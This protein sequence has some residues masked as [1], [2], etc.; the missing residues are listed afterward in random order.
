MNF[1]QNPHNLSQEI[2]HLE[3]SI[4]DFRKG[5]MH[6][7]QF[8]GIRVPFG[9]YEQRKDDTYMMRIRCAGG[10]ATPGQLAKVAEL[11]RQYGSDLI[12]ITTRQEMQ[13]HDV[14]LENVPDIMRELLKV[15]LSTRGGG[16]NT[17]R[18][19][20]ASHD[21]GVNLNEIFDVEPYA[22]ALTSRLI[23]ETDSWTLPR[24]FK[25]TFSSLA[26]NNANATVQDVGFI[27]QRKDGQKGFKVYVAGGMG[28]KSRLGHLLYEFVPADR[29]F[30]IVKAVKS[31]FY[32]HGNRKNKHRN[33][34]RFL[35][36]DLGED[37]FLEVF[38]QE[39]RELEK[40][41]SL[42][43]DVR[44][45]VNAT[46][47]A[48]D[49]APLSQDGTEYEHWRQ[50]YVTKQKQTGLVRIKLAL[51][52]GDISSEDVLHLARLL[53]PFG[54][55]LLR[56][57]MDQNI[58]LRNIPE[59]YLG[60]MFQGISKLKTLS[61]QPAM[62]GNMIACTGANTCKLGICLSR[63]VI[64]ATQKMLRD[65]GLD[66]EPLKE[67]KIHISGCPNSCGQHWTG[68]LGFFGVVRRKN[69]RAFPSY[70]V[71]AGAIAE[72]EK[73]QLSRLTSWVPAYDVPN[74]IWDILET[75]LSKKECSAS[76]NEYV[77]DGGKESIAALCEKYQD[78]P[79]FRDDKN[80]YFDW[81]AED[82]FSTSGMGQGECS[83]GLFDLIDLDEKSIKSNKAIT[84]SASN[85][86]EVIAALYNMVFSASRMLLVTKGIDA[87]SSEDVF[88]QFI[89]SFIDIGL[90]SDKY[91]EIVRLAQGEKYL[92]LLKRKDEVLALGD[93]VMSLYNSMDNSLTFP[94]EKGDR[95]VAE[96][97]PGPQRE[98]DIPVSG[99]KKPDRFK[100][101][102]GVQCPMNFVKTKIDLASMQAGQTLEIYLDDGAPID[103]VPRSVE[104]EG[105][106]ILTTTRT[107]NH[108]SVL[109]QKI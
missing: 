36:E 101:Y 20:T 54:E 2:E 23:A 30:Y 21:S 55:N 16:G 12:H 10:G 62:F 108:W 102:R 17:V 81:G 65:T 56:F 83:A 92:E 106:K 107:E 46:P 79:D 100:D 91:I 72:P 51:L 59:D 94:S 97:K 93:A 8:K 48:L 9:V 105:H 58:H 13:I 99:S 43:L 50:R 77:N 85:R 6:P 39:L 31:M 27:A 28:A 24:K 66:L 109:I 69:G 49:I 98:K 78:I 80:Y 67:L 68:D 18:N 42:I 88:E 15:G 19:I 3:K 96:T 52:L 104:G 90:I 37:R 25:I 75:F 61:D 47:P 34:L 11:A 76:F 71:V 70:N 103:N 60:N 63:G 74:L 57:S 22:V 1:Y 14:Q 33:R 95:D 73:S 32:K 82:V 87:R 86:E 4:L 29:V 26:T 89:K 5:R 38:H 41:P 40:D 35:W 84:E 45:I 44:E 53:K 7:T 64:P